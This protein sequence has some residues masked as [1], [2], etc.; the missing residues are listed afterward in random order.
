MH[1]WALA[2]HGCLGTHTRSY[3]TWTGRIIAPLLCIKEE[4]STVRWSYLNK[5]HLNCRDVIVILLTCKQK[6]RF[7][8]MQKLDV[9]TCVQELVLL[10]SGLVPP[11]TYKTLQKK[12]SRNWRNSTNLET[13]SYIS[14]YSLTWHLGNQNQTKCV[15]LLQAYK[16]PQHPDCSPSVAHCCLHGW[17]WCLLCSWFSLVSMW[18]SQ[19]KLFQR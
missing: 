10:C 11:E 8:L 19:G 9:M 15:Q 13:A 1:L 12:I 16:E 17:T 5:M 14:R 2:L 7:I 3:I 4:P 18:F 6:E